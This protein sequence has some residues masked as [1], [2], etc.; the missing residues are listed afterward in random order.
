[1]QPSILSW[2]Q[3]FTAISS[4]SRSFIT[5]I[6]SSP[7][8]VT[9]QHMLGHP[10]HLHVDRN[11][12]PRCRGVKSRWL[13]KKTGS[14]SLWCTGR[15]WEVMK[16]KSQKKEASASG[17]IRGTTQ[18]WAQK[19]VFLVYSVSIFL[20][21]QVHRIR[22][23]STTRLSLEYAPLP[24]PLPPLPPSLSLMMEDLVLPESNLNFMINKLN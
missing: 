13:G 11:I 1:M 5:P 19:W 8:Q 24:P 15:F 17:L 2:N 3:T 7:A 23:R 18:K 4:A 9:L 10:V 22:N 20:T 16:R 21:Q 6:S 12:G 14:V